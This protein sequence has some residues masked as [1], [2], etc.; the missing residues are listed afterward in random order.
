MKKISTSAISDEAQVGLNLSGFMGTLALFFTGILISQINNFANTIK[1]PIIYL[2]VSTFAFLFSAV[3]YANVTGLIT[4]KKIN[5][6]KKFLLVGNSLSEFL[7]LYLFILAIPMVI[8]AITNDTLLR[9]VIAS[10]SIISILLYTLSGFSI[11]DRSFSRNIRL[12]FSIIII[13]LAV[14]MYLAQAASK[15][16]FVIIA[17]ILLIAML[18]ATILSRESKIRN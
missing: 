13:P 5:R 8:I 6:T 4:T 3:V 18:V 16:Y 12:L 2:V 15:E 7:G 11:F 14:I 10:I 17:V 9:A 1:V